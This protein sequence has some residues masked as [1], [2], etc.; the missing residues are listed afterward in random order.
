MKYTEMKDARPVPL[1]DP[2]LSSSL[3]I[4]AVDQRRGCWGTCLGML[5]GLALVI[6]SSVTA[7]RC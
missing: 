7:T 6:L 1:Q 3:P 2:D 4:S 5:F